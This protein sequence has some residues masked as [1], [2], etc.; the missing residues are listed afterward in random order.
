VQ[1]SAANIHIAAAA[2]KQERDHP[3]HD[4]AGS[5]HPDH[6]AGMNLCGRRQPM[7][8]FVENEK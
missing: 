3:V 5:G 7:K 2:V 4:Y 1:K 6:Y 8:S